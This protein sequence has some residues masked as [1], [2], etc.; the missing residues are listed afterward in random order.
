M[1]C[2]NRDSRGACR[3]GPGNYCLSNALLDSPWRKVQR[4]RDRLAGVMEG[5]GPGTDEGHLIDQLMEI[6]ADDTR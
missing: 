2:S 3:L 4:G 6:L 1:C 5:V